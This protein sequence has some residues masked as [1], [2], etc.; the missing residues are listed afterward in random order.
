MNNLIAPKHPVHALLD[1]FFA[2]E[3]ISDVITEYQRKNKN[4]SKW[5]MF[6]DYCCS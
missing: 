5:L 6:S 4:Y 3:E 1:E 2:K